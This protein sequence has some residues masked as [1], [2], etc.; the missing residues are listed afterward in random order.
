MVTA[1][2]LPQPRG[3]TGIAARGATAQV[4]QTGPGVPPQNNISQ[5]ALHTEAFREI[6]PEKIGLY[7]LAEN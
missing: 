3:F 4:R 2:S 6:T 5:S 1:P 7:F